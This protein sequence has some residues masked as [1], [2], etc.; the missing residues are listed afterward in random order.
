MT[1][2]LHSATIERIEQGL[3]EWADPNSEA[4]RR[5]DAAREKWDRE[6]Q[7]LTDAIAA[8]ERLTERDMQIIVR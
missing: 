5:F 4:R 7:P 6:L 2:E 3:R 8:S 1:N